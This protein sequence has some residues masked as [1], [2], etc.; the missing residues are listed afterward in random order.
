MIRK[1]KSQEPTRIKVDL[2]KSKLNMKNIVL[3]PDRLKCRD[4]RSYSQNIAVL[5]AFKISAK[6][7]AQ[8]TRE[9]QK[10]KEITTK[11]TVNPFYIAHPI[12]KPK[13]VR[14]KFQ[15]FL[16]DPIKLKQTCK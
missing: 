10:R 12:K 13:E 7:T 8:I 6:L 1:T 15:D 2:N 5:K 14:Y 9:R 11:T 16:I 3:N 4:R